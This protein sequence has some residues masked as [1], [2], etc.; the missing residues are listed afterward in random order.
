MPKQN[1]TAPAIISTGLAYGIAFVAG[2]ITLIVEIVGTRFISPYYGSSLFVWSALITI[3]LISLAGGYEI[4]GRLADRYEGVKTLQTLLC[5][6]GA[7][8][9]FLPFVKNFVLIATTQLGLKA[10][11]LAS[12][13]ILFAAPL[14]FLSAT[15]PIIIKMTTP[16]L[17][18]V[19][20]RAGR[21]YF[22]STLGSVCGPALAS[23]L[24]IPNFAVSDIMRAAGLTLLL[25]ATF[26]FLA[27]KRF[28]AGLAVGLAALGA[29]FLFLRS[30]PKL[31]T[32]ILE[33]KESFYG[34][35]K[36]ADLPPRRALL[37]D[38]IIQSL[39]KPLTQ[40]N[41]LAIIDAL[42]FAAWLRPQSRRALVM[43]LG[44]GMLPMAFEKFYGITTDTVEIN[45]A[46]I[47]AA[48]KY[49]NYQT[50]GATAPEDGRTFARKAPPAAYGIII[51]DAFNGENVPFHLMSQ[52]FFKEAKRL[53]TPNGVI[54]INCLGFNQPDPG[55]ACRAVAATLKTQFQFV[56]HFVVPEKLALASPTSNVVLFASN[57]DMENPASM[58]AAREAAAA[59]INAML[60]KE[61][62][63]EQ[64]SAPI[65]TDEFNPIDLYTAEIAQTLRLGAIAHSQSALLYD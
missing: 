32:N 26:I 40:E 3:T 62:Q 47:A 16:S 1:P 7:L 33:T 59:T 63:W 28:L 42:E 55:F 4:G 8:L 38:G 14:L 29:A 20:R 60:K 56:R 44:A 18:W 19:G 31:Q 46:I 17:E 35:I 48:Q 65:L 41:E 50:R 2:S 12:A 61:I 21:V 27:Q 43:G 25:C 30:G 51:I 45:P 15:G 24:L 10:G 23:F 54:A 57:A 5:G 36:I 58:R 39:A 22:Y 6:A 11:A 37:L 64:N 9:M 52:E 49:F 53:L 13:A 34:Q